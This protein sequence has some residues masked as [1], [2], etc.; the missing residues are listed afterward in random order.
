MQR[1]WTRTPSAISLP[2]DPSLNDHYPCQGKRAVRR[3]PAPLQAHHR[4][5]GSS[6]RTAR[7]RVLREAHCRTQAQ[8][9]RGRQASLQARSQHAAAQ[10]A[11]LKEFRGA[12][13]LVSCG[14]ARKR[15]HRSRKPVRDA[16]AG[17][18]HFRSDYSVFKN[19]SESPTMT[20]K[21]RISDDM[22]TAMRAKE[23][24]RLLAIRNLM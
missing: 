7:P 9:G 14:S 1:V 2:K 11:L 21:Q 19:G 12:L 10:E 17:F 6:D 16:A 13:E 15:R 18:F 20:L 22:K 24:D 5:A 3:G 4:K 8:E 23:A